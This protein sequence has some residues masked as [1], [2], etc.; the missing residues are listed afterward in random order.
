MTTSVSR[1]PSPFLKTSVTPPTVFYRQCCAGNPPPCWFDPSGDNRPDHAPNDR[2]SAC[3]SNQ[4]GMAEASRHPCDR[5]CRASGGCALHLRGWPSRTHRGT[6]PRRWSVFIQNQERRA[7][8]SLP[9]PVRKPDARSSV[10]KPGN[11]SAQGVQRHASVKRSPH[12]P[13]GTTA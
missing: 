9:H 5:L 1:I 7:L 11:L 8:R 3:G 4:A 6:S 2:V 10:G 13:G 12:K